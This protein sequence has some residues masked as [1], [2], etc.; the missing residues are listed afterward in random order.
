MATLSLAHIQKNLALLSGWKHEDPHI[1]KR[2]LWK[3]FQEALNFVNK[4]GVVAE[5][6]GHHPDI[7]IKNYNQ[8]VVRTM[9]HDEKGITEKDF[10]LARAIES[11]NI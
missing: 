2:Y 3:D 5:R 4:I 10:E 11:I 7:E 6:L 9:T 1:T 8:V